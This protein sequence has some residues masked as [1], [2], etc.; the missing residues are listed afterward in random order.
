MKTYIFRNG[1]KKWK[2]KLSENYDL[3]KSIKLMKSFNPVV[4]PRNHKV[5]EVLEAANHNDFKPF[6]Q[7]LE[8]LRKPYENKSGILNYQIPNKSINKY[9]TYCGT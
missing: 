6:N 2:N 5:E 4:I 1:K 3:D 9:K 7:F 8:I